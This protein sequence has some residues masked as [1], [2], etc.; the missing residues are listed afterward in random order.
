MEMK[1]YLE[2]AQQ[3]QRDLLGRLMVD[4]QTQTEGF[5]VWVH[6]PTGEMD[7]FRFY[8]WDGKKDEELGKMHDYAERLLNRNGRK[9]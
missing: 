9:V 6:G 2:K 7:S 5:T 4:I 3:L 8:A 1:D